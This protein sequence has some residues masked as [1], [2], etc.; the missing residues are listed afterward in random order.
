MIVPDSL[1]ACLTTQSPMLYE[2]MQLLLLT[3]ILQQLHWV[4]RD[5]TLNT[6]EAKIRVW[7]TC[8]SVP[9]S[10]RP[11]AMAISNMAAPG[12]MER[13]ATMWSRSSARAGSASCAL[14]LRL[15]PQ[16]RD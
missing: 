8:Q 16:H 14:S 9:L 11:A 2:L 1:L 5:L 12:R 13:P 6:G 4:S 10:A 3:I 15:P 7:S